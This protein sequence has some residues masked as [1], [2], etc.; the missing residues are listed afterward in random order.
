MT[1]RQVA[2]ET[3]GAISRRPHPHVTIATSL[4][5]FSISIPVLCLFTRAERCGAF[6]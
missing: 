5:F 3:K 2:N 6:C 1:N 4:F